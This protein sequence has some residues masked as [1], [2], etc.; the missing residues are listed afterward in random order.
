MR[1]KLEADLT[2]QRLNNLFILQCSL[3]LPILAY[4]LVSDSNLTMFTSREKKITTYHTGMPCSLL[5]MTCWW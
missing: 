3:L 4:F 2:I 1:N 5:G